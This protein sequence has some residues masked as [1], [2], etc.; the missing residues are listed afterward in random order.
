MRRSKLY[1]IIILVAIIGLNT[2][3]ANAQNSSN[4]QVVIHTAKPYFITGDVLHYKVYFPSIWLGKDKVLRACLIKNDNSLI[5]ESF[6]KTSGK[7]SISNMLKIP[8]NISSGMY[9]LVLS[10][11]HKELNKEITIAEI[12]V[13][14]YADLKNDLTDLQEEHTSIKNVPLNSNLKVDL[15]INNTLIQKRSA[16]DG[17][18]SIKDINGNLKEPDASITVLDQAQLIHGYSSVHTYPSI[19]GELIEGLSDEIY[20]YGYFKSLKDQQKKRFPVVS[21]YSKEENNFSYLQ[22]NEE[23]AFSITIKDFLGSKGIQFLNYDEEEI[24]IELLTPAISSTT[25]KLIVNDNIIELLEWSRQR[26]KIDQIFKLNTEEVTIKQTTWEKMPI[27]KAKEYQLESYE[28]FEDIYTLFTEVMS[29]MRLRK[30]KDG[31]YIAQVFNRESSSRG[32]YPGQPVFIVDGLATK[33]AN[34]INDLDLN[35]VN[36]IKIISDLPTLRKSYGP[37]G[38]SGVIYVD[39]KLPEVR[40]PDNEMNNIIQVNGFRV[41]QEQAIAKGKDNTIPDLNSNIYWAPDLQTIKEGELAFQFDHSDDLGEFLIEV[42]A[43]DK[44]GQITKSTFTYQVE[45]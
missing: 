18:I 4:N 3:I 37:I 1:R 42:V 10:S 8:L 30:Q 24:S 35:M 12:F 21:I 32:Y 15:V 29:A 28:S 20:L 17:Q 38:Q 25:P 36:T 31:T 22:S 9:H 14:I 26:R 2:Q 6:L 7:T 45:Q 41:E 13:P 5:D 43:Q 39:T 40:L 19:E 27:E 16:I 34:F 44:N 23:G 11:F 33:D